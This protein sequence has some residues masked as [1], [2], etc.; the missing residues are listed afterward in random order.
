MDFLSSGE[1]QLKV[2]KAESELRLQ[3]GGRILLKE[4]DVDS[5]LLEVND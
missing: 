3:D 2:G 5:L 4:F 1:I